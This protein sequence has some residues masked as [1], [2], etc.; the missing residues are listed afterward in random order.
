MHT[1]R[2]ARHATRLKSHLNCI[3]WL[4]NADAFPQF[5][6]LL[7]AQSPAQNNQRDIQFGRQY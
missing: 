3:W 2:V 1:W 4:L 7:A 6:F 5:R